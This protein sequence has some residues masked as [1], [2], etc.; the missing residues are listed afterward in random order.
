[1]QLR[2]EKKIEK[3]HYYISLLES[4]KGECKKV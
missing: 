4:Y 3:L 1:M 2:I